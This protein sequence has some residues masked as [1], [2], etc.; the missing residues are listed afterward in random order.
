M[1]TILNKDTNLEIIK[2]PLFFGE[3]LSIQRYD[4]FKYEKIYNMFKQHLSYFW[5]PEEIQVSRDRGDFQLLLPHEKFIFT[6]N[7]SYQILLDSVQSRGIPYLL[8][9]CSNPEVELFA[10]MWEFSE[11]IHSYSYTY[12][13]KNIYSDPSKIF[14][15]ILSDE[16]ISQRATS[17]TKYYDDMISNLPEQT[18]REKKKKLYLNLASINILEG[19]R[20]YVSFACSFCFAQNKKMEGN[21]KIIS[22]ICFDDQTDILT[23]KGWKKLSDL[24]S[25]ELVAQYHDNGDISFVHPINKIEQD[26]KGE[27]YHF[28]NSRHNF[29]ITG[30]HR[31]IYREGGKLKESLAKNFNPSCTKSYIVSGKGTG[32]K[33]QLNWIERF[34]IAFQA[35]G[36]YSHPK[37]NHPDSIPV[38]FAFAKERKK[39]RFK[40]I[41]NNLG[42]EYSERVGC[43][44]KGN[45]KEQIVFYLRVPKEIKLTKDFSW[46][47]VS[48][49]SYLGA[50]DFINEITLWDGHRRTDTNGLRYDTTTPECADIV[51]AI[52][53]LTGWRTNTGVQQDRRN[54]S[55][56]DI[57]RVYIDPTKDYDNCG[58]KS[59]VL[60]LI[61]YE[62][63][64]YCV[65]VPT[66]MVVVRRNGKAVISGNCRDENMH[67][68]FTSQ[69]MKILRD[70]PEEGF[71]DI[72]SECESFVLQMYKDA[73]QEE[74][75]WIQYIFKDG[76]MIGLNSEIL[77]TYMK[78]L[79]NQRLK[80]IGLPSIFEKVQNPISWIN[81]WTSGSTEVQVAPQETEIESYV[82]G[83]LKQ[84]DE[85][86]DYSD[87]L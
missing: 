58:T 77:S 41:L 49:Y 85:N 67:M 75:D 1:K 27:L 80:V 10:K 23:D 34:K 70:V 78:Y 26:F 5:R 71:Q 36:C 6:K 48:D 55:Y 11:T 18:E 82:I 64:V 21:A 74:L 22:L 42:W 8:Q 86:A 68:G 73:A 13:I 47:N 46:V 83:A 17:V 72:V 9:N 56:K 20:F 51:H 37:R 35:D 61:P 59:N 45:R 40:E 60:K 76:S 16:K 15:E 38:I 32:K 52:G 69:L 54:K 62:G 4:K 84:A 28:S 25:T 79:T 3:G 66:G 33:D 53:V 12:I 7:L 50:R 81:R 19:I 29:A 30:D 63:K 57:H 44:E 65:T 43:K 31:I 24:G 39:E 14:D 87:F 2:S